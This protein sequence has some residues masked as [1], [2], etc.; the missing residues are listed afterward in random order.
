MTLA[1]RLAA[2][3][4]APL[5]VLREQWQRV[6]ETEPPRVG[7]ELLR[8]G[9]AYTLQE[10]RYGS[11]PAATVRQLRAVLNP[12][13]RAGDTSAAIRPGTRLVRSWRGETHH[14]EVLAEGY[15]YQ[16]Q[17]YTSLSQIARLITGTCWSGPRFFGLIRTKRG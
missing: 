7:T 10:R 1:T 16:E 5:A 8:L 2:L 4:V 17:N 9:I 15:L 12:N 11:L 6:Y 14:V 13:G 3:E